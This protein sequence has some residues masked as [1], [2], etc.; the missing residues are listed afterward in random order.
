MIKKESY[1][2]SAKSPKYARAY[3]YA[4]QHEYKL[5]GIKNLP[6]MPVREGGSSEPN[7][8]PLD[9]PLYI[10]LPETFDDTGSSAANPYKHLSV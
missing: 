7:E 10:A 4:A 6:C 1:A 2:A 8:P 5:H 3:Y 9:P